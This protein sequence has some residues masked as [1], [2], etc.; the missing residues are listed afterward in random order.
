MN[1]FRYPEE[2]FVLVAKND[3][4]ESKDGIKRTIRTMGTRTM[5][6]DDKYKTNLC[7]N[8]LKKALM[9]RRDES[10]PVDLVSR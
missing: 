1:V 9:K 10:C 6:K 2:N 7:K 4:E 5:E 3:E 8:V